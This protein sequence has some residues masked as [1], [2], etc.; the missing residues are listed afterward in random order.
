MAKYIIISLILTDLLP[1]FSYSTCLEKKLG[2]QPI[3]KKSQVHKSPN[4]GLPAS[5]SKCL[6]FSLVMCGLVQFSFVISIQN[7]CKIRQYRRLLT[8]KDYSNRY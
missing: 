6:L 7:F 4:P 3:S 5:L 2:G 1:I 8:L